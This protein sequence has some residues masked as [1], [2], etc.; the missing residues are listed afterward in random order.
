MLILPI[1]MKIE[2]SKF[3]LGKDHK[4]TRAGYGGYQFPFV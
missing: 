4:V 2:S 1:F 3:V